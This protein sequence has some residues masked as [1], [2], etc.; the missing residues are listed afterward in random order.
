[1]T[2]RPR[3][4][5]DDIFIRI[6]TNSDSSSD[7]IRGDQLL[8]VYA[9]VMK[10]TSPIMDAHVTVHISV[11]NPNGSEEHMK[12]ALLDNGNGGTLDYIPLFKVNVD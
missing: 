12:L 2:S 10:G 4:G 5:E 6:W 8:A 9:E 1:M 3:Y 7:I 11:T